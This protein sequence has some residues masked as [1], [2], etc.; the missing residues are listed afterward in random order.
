MPKLKTNKGAKKRFR[1]TARGKI[2][3]SRTGK[4]HLLSSKSAKRRR[5]LRK[6]TT[7]HSFNTR[8]AQRLLCQEGVAPP[9]P[10]PPPKPSAP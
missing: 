10:P 3:F 2:L 1:I 9:H 4:G 6:A 8:L 5:H 7:F